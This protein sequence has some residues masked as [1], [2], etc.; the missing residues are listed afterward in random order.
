MD[1]ILFSLKLA[2]VSLRTSLCLGGEF[3]L[4][5]FKV[6]WVLFILRALLVRNLG[7]LGE[8]AQWAGQGDITVGGLH[9]P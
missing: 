6:S 8:A 7:S 9:L 3:L 5:V 1:C 2:I 4:T